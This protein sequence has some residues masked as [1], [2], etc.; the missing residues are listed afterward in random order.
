MVQRVPTAPGRGVGTLLR[1]KARKAP[2]RRP[3][4]GGC[5][6]YSPV[7]VVLYFWNTSR[8]LVYFVFT[9]ATLVIPPFAAAFSMEWSPL[10][11]KPRITLADAVPDFGP[12]T[13]PELLTGMVIVHELR[14]ATAAISS[15]DL[16]I[17]LR[18][19]YQPTIELA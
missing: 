16:F 11:C 3:Y 12:V 9:V 10:K 14:S 17:F 2:E 7:T 8:T 13:G 18:I 6:A 4:D 5:T 19:C 15:Q 1:H